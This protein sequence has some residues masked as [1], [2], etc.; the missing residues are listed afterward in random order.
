MNGVFKKK[1]GR[2]EPY[3]RKIQIDRAQGFFLS[4]FARS[5]SLKH[6]KPLCGKVNSRFHSRASG[7]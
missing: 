5:T 3:E 1:G 7:L 6:P 4:A 2:A